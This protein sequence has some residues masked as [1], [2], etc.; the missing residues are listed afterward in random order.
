MGLAPCPAHRVWVG[1]TVQGHIYP[2]PPA[3]S[4][5][6]GPVVVVVV[7]LVEVAQFTTITTTITRHS[8]LEPACRGHWT[9]TLRR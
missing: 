5:P 3:L 9:C 1:M 7:Y 4:A 6:A 2:A 8:L